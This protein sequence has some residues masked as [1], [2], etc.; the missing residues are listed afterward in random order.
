MDVLHKDVLHQPETGTKLASGYM[1]A[2]MGTHSQGG[3]WTPPMA[4]V[5]DLGGG[6]T[7]DPKPAI[8]VLIV[9]GYY[10]PQLEHLISLVQGFFQKISQEGAKPGFGEIFGGKV[11]LNSMP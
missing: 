3:T 1:I 7:L 2:R 4:F 8:S 11:E 6:S 5:Q 9:T 10:N